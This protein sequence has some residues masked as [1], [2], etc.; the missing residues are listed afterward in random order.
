[1]KAESGLTLTVEN[2]MEMAAK[3]V[4]L[5]DYGDKNFQFPLEQ[6]LNSF[7]QEYGDNIDRKFSFGYTIIDLLT[8]RL[9]I[10]DNFKS[11][12][13]ILNTPIKRPLFITGLPR[14]GTTL[15]HNLLSQ[16][17]YWRILPYWELVYPYYRAEFGANFE[18][19]SIRLTEQIIKG[20]YSRYPD[21]IYR[22]ETTAEGPEECVH[23]LRY[24]FYSN[25]FAVEW[26]LFGYLKWYIEQDLTDSY[27]YYKKLL[28]LLLWRKSKEY[29]LLKCP[30]HLVGVKAILDVFPDA[31][32][33]WMHRNPF[34]T[35]ASALSLFSVFRT[36]P[37]KLDDFI[38]LYLVYFKKSL[39]IVMEKAKSSTKQIKSVS[40]NKLVKN[41]LEV[42]REI[43]EEFNYPLDKRDEE[44]ISRWLKENPQ[45]KH[46]VHKYNLEKFGLSEAYVE[47]LLSQYFEEYGHLL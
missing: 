3:K 2:L 42:T 40:Y 21:L 12:P 26:D 35:I 13:E 14:T 46:G 22:H 38:E 20:L 28:Q 11:Y 5:D 31:N 45:H 10:R 1:M 37:T 33:V 43:Y 4:R 16:N 19:H 47:N 34:K 39:Q 6:L 18:Q 36:I 15:L 41:P 32:L 17:Q 8:K 29:L 9:Y 27:S 24:T 44:N 25:S 7:E 30:A 23:L